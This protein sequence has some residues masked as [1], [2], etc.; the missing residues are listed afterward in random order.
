MFCQNVISEIGQGKLIV[1]QAPQLYD[2]GAAETIAIWLASRVKSDR[3]T[4]FCMRPSRLMKNMP[5]AGQK[6][7]CQAIDC[8][9]KAADR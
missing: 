4:L 1:D 8:A 3:P 2:I 9:R 7:R 6:A 5:T